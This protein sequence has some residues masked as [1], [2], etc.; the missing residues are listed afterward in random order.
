MIK[1]RSRGYKR[2]REGGE[3]SKSLYQG[4][5][6]ANKLQNGVLANLVLAAGL[7]LP[8]PHRRSSSSYL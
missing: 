2:A 8:G 6:G 5:S 4:G 1:T 3:A 7:R